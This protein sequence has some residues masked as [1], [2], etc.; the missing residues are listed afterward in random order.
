MLQ[1]LSADVKSHWDVLPLLT[2]T[3]PEQKMAHLLT[4]PQKCVCS[5]MKSIILLM[6]FRA[7]PFWSVQVCNGKLVACNAAKQI[8]HSQSLLFCDL[9]LSDV[10]LQRILLKFPLSCIFLGSC[11]ETGFTAFFENQRKYAM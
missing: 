1:V 4:N 9:L 8:K 6:D 2:R 7:L 10:Y 5:L 11:F 3:F